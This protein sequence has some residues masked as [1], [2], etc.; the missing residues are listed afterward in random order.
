MNSKYPQWDQVT[1]GT[2]LE[3]E[4]EGPVSVPNRETAMN[5][6]GDMVVTTA[7]RGGIA[8]GGNS[9]KVFHSSKGKTMLTIYSNEWNY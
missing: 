9:G 2:D 1:H 3:L 7:Y 4:S 5:T 8:T 6:A